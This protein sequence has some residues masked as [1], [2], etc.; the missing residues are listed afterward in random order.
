MLLLKQFTDW[1]DRMVSS[2][3]FQSRT[4]DGKKNKIQLR[5]TINSLILI[6]I[7]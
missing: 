7:S 2:V 1:E 5:F 3:K 6:L 4:D